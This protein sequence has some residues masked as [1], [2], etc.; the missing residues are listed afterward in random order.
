VD[1]VDIVVDLKASTSVVDRAVEH[2]EPVE[3]I[4]GVV[5][6]EVVVGIVA[7]VD[8]ALVGLA[9]AD[10]EEVDLASVATKLERD[11]KTKEEIG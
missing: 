9:L 3:H 2:I 1:T 5:G 11:W 8:L 10:L 4:E 6:I 7:L